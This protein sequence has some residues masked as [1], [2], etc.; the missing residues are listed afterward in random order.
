MEIVDVAARPFQGNQS[1]DSSDD[2]L[3]RL[4]R[5]WLNANQNSTN[6][7]KI[8]SFMGLQWRST[9]QC[10]I[11]KT[12]FWDFMDGMKLSPRGQFTW[13]AVFLILFFSQFTVCSPGPPFWLIC[14]WVTPDPILFFGNS[15]LPLQ[16]TYCSSYH[17]PSALPPTF[18]SS[19][20]LLLL[21]TSFLPCAFTSIPTAWEIGTA[22]GCELALWFR[23]QGFEFPQLQEPEKGR[24]FRTVERG[25]VT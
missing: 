9:H 12:P 15:Y 13:S 5:A 4:C 23:F 17:P 18:A 1:S 16:P 3:V 8:W 2:E 14:F 20:V 19:S 10:T 24:A 7:A 25:R 21:S 11:Q 22:S 6:R